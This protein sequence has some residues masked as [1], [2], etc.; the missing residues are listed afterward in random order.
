LERVDRLADTAAAMTVEEFGRRVGREAANMRRDD[1]ME[2]FERQQRA[3]RVRSWTD[4]DGM[5]NL[6]GRFDP[7]TGVKLNAAL[8]AALEALF[9]ETVPEFCPADPIEKQRFLAGHALA[10][11]MLGEHPARQAGRPEYVVVIDADAP[12][13][14]G[15]VACWSIPIE[16]PTR[17]LAGLVGEGRV[18]TVIVRNGVVL[19]A[20]GNVNL[21]R[22]TRLA[23][24]DQ[25]RA[26]RGL[27][28]G[29]AMPGC[30]VG[31]DH[32]KLHHIIWW[33]HG[34]RTDLD[35]LIPLCSKHHSNIHNDHW[36]ITL[37]PQRELTLTL[38]NGTIQ[39]TGP[40]TIHDP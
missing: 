33:R 28:R 6:A 34:G 39:T 5:F 36:T 9:A 15:P 1:G 37:G 19:H 2:R 13:R 11:L 10:R 40:P 25:R 38:P 30:G 12:D 18:E 7:V 20:P 16:V 29:C 24:R 17:V 22:S 23:N 32:C 21:G 27:Y 8:T 26:L 31:Y 3:V 35:N 14:A 4:D